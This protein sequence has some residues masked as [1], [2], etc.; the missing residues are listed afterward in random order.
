MCV[1]VSFT[2]PLNIVRL[3]G[4]KIVCFNISLRL[5]DNYNYYLQFLDFRLLRRI[6]CILTWREKLLGLHYVSDLIVILIRIVMRSRIRRANIQER[7]FP[8]ITYSLS[9]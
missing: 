7:E 2:V 5:I 1:S 8:G 4:R 9:V 6:R 3:N